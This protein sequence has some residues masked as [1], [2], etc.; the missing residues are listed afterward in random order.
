MKQIITIFL[1]SLILT[2]AYTQDGSPDNTFGMNGKVITSI[3]TGT[4]RGWSVELQNDGKIVVAGRSKNGYYY[5][6]AVVRYNTDGTL[7]PALGNGGKVVTAIGSSE[8]L[9][10]SIAIQ[11]DVKKR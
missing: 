8:D 10:Y 9:A 5:D 4:D 3:G 1:L 6:F 2:Q 7:D 11:N